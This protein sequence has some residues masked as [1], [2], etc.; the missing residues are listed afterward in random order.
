MITPAQEISPAVIGRYQKSRLRLLLLLFLSYI[1][2]YFC[3]VNLVAALP[4]LETAFR[5]SKT[6]T[7]LILSAY[8]TLYS[9]GKIINGFAGDRAG[10][11]AMLLIGIGGSTICNV[12]FG[13]GRELEFFIIVW[14]FNAFFQSMGWLSMVSIMSQWYS[15]AESGKAMGFLSLSYLLGDFG[16]RSSASLI[17]G[18]GGA[19]WPYLFW[20]HAALFA[21]IGVLASWF[22]KSK[23]ERIGLPGVDVY[24][25]YLRAGPQECSLPAE[26][27]SRASI[28]TKK[29]AWLLVMLQSRWFWLTCLIYLGFSVIRYIFWT[30]SILYLRESGMAT[31]M[32]VITSAVFPLLGSFG[33]IAAGWASDKLNARRGPV[34]AVMA[35]LMVAGI[36]VFGRIPAAH[37]VFMVVTLGFIGFMLTGPYS[38]FAGAMAIDFGSRHSAAAASGIIDAIGAVGAMLSGAGMGY[39]IDRYQWNGAFTIVT[40]IAVLTTALCFPLWKLRPLREEEIS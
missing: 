11:K 39:L 19:S 18:L 7:G 20:I 25:K 4:F 23:P 37:P 14:S 21:G 33:A 24:S 6:Q 1:G 2:F 26:V 40:G 9:I 3:R 13:F 36:Y 38:L 12:V 34:I 17:I 22:V 28:K 16:A 8:F 29:K 10:G 32:A 5:F 35:S 15:S 27:E 31:G 30:W